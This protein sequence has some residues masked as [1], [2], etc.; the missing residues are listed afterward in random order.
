MQKHTTQL[1][2]KQIN[3]INLL[4]KNGKT[5]MIDICQQL[6]VVFNITAD[7][8]RSAFEHQMKSNP[9]PAK[10]PKKPNYQEQLAALGMDQRQIEQLLRP[11]EDTWKSSNTIVNTLT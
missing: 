10:K 8:A 6:M 5:K 9:L 1:D 2:K 7:E 4:R 3:Y 11:Q